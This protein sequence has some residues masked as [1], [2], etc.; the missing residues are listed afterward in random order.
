MRKTILWLVTALLA[1]V[2]TAN[3]QGYHGEMERIYPEQQTLARRETKKTTATR[4]DTAEPQQ[5]LVPYLQQLGQELL[6]GKT[7]SIVAEDPATGE[8][9]CLV[10]NSPNGPDINLAIATAYAPGSTFK[11]AQAL[12]LLSEGIVGPKTSVG[13]RGVLH[14]GSLKVGCHKHPSPLMLPNALAHSCNTWFLKAFRSLLL[15]KK[16]LNKDQAIDRWRDYMTSMGLGGP[17]GVDI[18]GEKGGLVANSRYLYRRYSKGWTPQ[19]V[20]WVGMGQGDITATPLQ[21]CNMVASVANRGYFFRPHVHRGTAAQ[22]L[23]QRYLIRRE[24]M[25]AKW[26]YK[27]VISGMRGAVVRGTAAAI[28]TPAYAICGKTGT[29]ENEGKDHSAFIGFAPMNNPRIAIA[30]FV[31]NGGFGAD[32]AAPIAAKI[33]KAY[34]K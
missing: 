22:P 4:Q 9:L 32:V 8:L 5:T 31:E 19:T 26:A 12:A 1:I 34:L 18:P 7:G 14:E 21:L 20:I 25:V 33:I 27:P 29:V 16:Y 15:S 10:T 30:V 6:K 17:T 3:A 2:T 23:A 11:V 28:N 13:C 24:T